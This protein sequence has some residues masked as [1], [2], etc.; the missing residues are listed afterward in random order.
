MNPCRCGYFGDKNHTCTCPPQ[1]IKKY[2]GKISGP[3]L[4]R[5]DLHAEV[6]SLSYDELSSSSLSESSDSIK[7]RVNNARSIQ[8]KR[9]EGTAIHS[10][11][12]LYPEL[13][14]K[15]CA[16]GKE[17]HKLLRTAF[18]NMGLS[19]RAYDRILKV[20]RTIAD[21]EGSENICSEHIFEAIQY[22]TLDRKYWGTN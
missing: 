20:A 18:D 21:L 12:E 3:L 10:N 15:Y 13:L 1:S 14:R 7:K 11:A 16:L 2:I 9:Y 4:D 8:K 6:S 19:A 22:R 17:E 5:I